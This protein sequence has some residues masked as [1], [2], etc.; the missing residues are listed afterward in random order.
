[1]RVKITLFVH[2]TLELKQQV[3]VVQRVNKP[4]VA[5]V[6][7]YAI[8][9]AVTRDLHDSFFLCFCLKIDR[10]MRRVYCLGYATVGSGRTV[11]L[12]FF[13]FSFYFFRVWKIS[14]MTYLFVGF[15]SLFFLFVKFF[16]GSVDIKGGGCLKLFGYNIIWIIPQTDT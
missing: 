13:L 10:V 15:L 6:F 5:S 14:L 3:E 2:Q 16:S 4:R 11:K 8:V 1:M 9:T 12:F 7:Y